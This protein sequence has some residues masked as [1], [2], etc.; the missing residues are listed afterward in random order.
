MALSTEVPVPQ[1]AVFAVVQMTRRTGDRYRDVS[2]DLRHAVCQWL[3][4][5]QAPAH[6]MTLVT[7]GGDLHEDEQV[8]VFSESLLPGLRIA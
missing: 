6:F 3:H 1:T 2:D 7:A 5:Q 8:L 4:A